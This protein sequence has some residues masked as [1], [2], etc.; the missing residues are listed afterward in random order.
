MAELRRLLATTD[1]S[2]MGNYA[3]E[4]AAR[5]AQDL[6]ASLEVVHV[7]TP[8]LVEKLIGPSGSAQQL[9]DA[10][11]EK[12]SALATSLHETYG[13]SCALHVTSGSLIQGIVNCA[14][15]VRADLIVLGHQGDSLMR[16][17]LL[18]ST[19]ERLATKAP[20]PFLVV[21]RAPEEAY[22][23]LL[24]A[25]DFSAVSMR[26]LVLAHTLVPHA[27]ISVMHAYEAPFEGKLKYVGV[28]KTT[29]R[30]YRHTV[31][32]E[33]IPALQEFCRAAGFSGEHASLFAVHG[34][35]AMQ[36]VSQSTLRS[37]DL[38]VIGKHGESV[39]ENLFIGSVASS[40]M[41]KAHCDILVAV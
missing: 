8:F 15:T 39:L 40:V 35:P 14:E 19:A 6:G 22:R 21:K 28:E 4:R 18:G 9:F 29:L 32:Q 1:F 30:Q 17:F 37:C 13:V 24:V 25:T 27:K 16:H 20:C 41:T 33:I 26:A 11:R 12:L 3:V 31:R 7:V 10:A 23:S 5:L 36:I 34:K 38:I 2:T